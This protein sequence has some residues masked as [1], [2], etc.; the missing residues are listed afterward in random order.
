MEFLTSIFQ[1][2]LVGLD[3]GISGIKAVELRLGKT[4]SLVAYNRISLPWNSITPEGIIKDDVAI[5]TALQKLFSGKNFSTKNMSVGVF[6]NAILSKSINIPQM[7]KKEID[8]QIY[9]EA[10]QYIPFNIEECA[11]DFSVIGNTV[12]K[13]DVAAP[14]QIEVLLVAAK[15][16]Y[17]Q[18]FTGVIERA[19]LIPIVID[20]QPFALG[21]CFEFNYG[22]EVSELVGGEIDLIIDFGAGSTKLSF[23]EK[24]HIVQTTKLNQCGSGYTLLIS[25]R[26]GETYEQAEIV[27]L[28][29]PDSPLIS[30]IIGDY[31]AHL[32]SEIQK[33]IDVFLGQMGDRSL[34]KIYYC[35]GASRTLGLLESIQ[36][37]Y[38]SQVEPLNPLKKLISSSSKSGGRIINDLICWGSVAVGLALRKSGDN[39]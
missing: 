21:N 19:G 29:E 14:A 6:G 15:K 35:G 38:P 7:A 24:N 23:I 20:Y 2:R 17:I 27:K 39:R 34:R 25:E 26:M 36:N 37:K 5:I 11:L 30:P 13:L 31:N 12:Q 8:D 16:E 22:S 33:S 4:N 28:N 18:S 1:K 32:T 3:I 9:W 10:E